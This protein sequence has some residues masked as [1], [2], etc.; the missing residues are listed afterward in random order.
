MFR[1]SPILASKFVD[2]DFWRLTLAHYRDLRHLALTCRAIR[3]PSYE[4]L[5]KHLAID[6]SVR[7]NATCKIVIHCLLNA[8][9]RRPDLAKRARS[10]YI[11]LDPHVL[12]DLQSTTQFGTSGIPCN[13]L[14]NG[15]KN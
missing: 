4:A 12:L 3:T 1:T 6:N 15:C 10:V 9:Q 8:L 14:R 7:R 11:G 2:K 13:V 5:F